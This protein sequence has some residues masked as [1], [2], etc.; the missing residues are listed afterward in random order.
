MPKPFPYEDDHCVP[1][2]YDISMIS[3]RTWRIGKEEVCSNISSGLVGLTRS[4]WCYTFEELEKRRK[5]LG[6]G[7]TELIRN[8]VTTEEAEEFLRTIQKADYSVIQ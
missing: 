7:T 3:T 6:K 2:N 8:K 4:G 5:E 1:W